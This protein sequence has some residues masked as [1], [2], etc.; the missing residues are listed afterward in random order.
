M[1]AVLYGAKGIQP[2]RRQGLNKAQKHAQ[3]LLRHSGA[4]K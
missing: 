4:W 2:S 3:W 1:M